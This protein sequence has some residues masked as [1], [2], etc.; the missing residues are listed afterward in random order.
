MCWRIAGSR[1]LPSAP[2]IEVCGDDLVNVKFG[3]TGE[4]A[5]VAEAL[6]RETGLLEI[7]PGIDSVVVQ[8]DAASI[9]GVEVERQVR[10]IIEAGVGP[11]ESAGE[12][13][14]IPVVYG[15]EAGPDFDAVC[16]RT[17]LTPDE[18]IALHTGREYLVDLVGFTPGFAFIGGLDST[19]NVPRRTEPRQ[20]VAPGSIGIA[21]G[22][23]GL[24]ALPVPGGWQLI[25][26][27][28]AE[29]FNADR[30][31]PNLLG[32]GDRVRFVAVPAP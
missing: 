28:D 24:Y 2:E 8:F 29:L 30:D 3:S 23:T 11:I 5:A 7:V 15:G 16:Q 1:F 21:D 32:V 18:L 14:E 13:I 19:L 6:R 31:P 9:D 25:G 26:R 17:G 22:R 27:T 10:S 4:A 12:L 20:Q